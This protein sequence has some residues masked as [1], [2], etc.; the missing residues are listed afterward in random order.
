MTQGGSMLRGVAL[1]RTGL[2]SLAVLALV[3]AGCAG[4]ISPQT[5][6]AELVRQTGVPPASEFEFTMGRFTTALLKSALG[7]GADGELPLAGLTGVELAVYGLPLATAER[8]LDFS[9]MTPYGWENVVRYKEGSKS[10]LVMIRGGSESIQDLALVAA[11]ETEVVYGRLRG[12]L[13]A[14]LPEAIRDA[15]ARNGTAGVKRELLDAAGTS[16]P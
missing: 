4:S 5:V 14:T 7:P 13:P 8:Y 9:Q 6:R 2:G 10:V 16:E 12:H 11:G 1:R 15:V 3:T